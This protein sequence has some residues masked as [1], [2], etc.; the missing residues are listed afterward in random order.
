MSSLPFALRIG[1]ALALLLFG[2]VELLRFLALLT[3]VTGFPALAAA[4]GAL[5]LLAAVS[6]VG[7]WLRTPWA[8]VAILAIGCVFA[9]THLIEALVLGIRPWLFALLAAVA[10]LGAASLLAVWARA[11]ARPL[12]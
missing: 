1:A 11:E 4:H 6:G 8:P 7:L 9:A 12:S 5:A 2:L 3:S 10:A